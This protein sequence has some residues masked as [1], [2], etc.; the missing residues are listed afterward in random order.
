MTLFVMKHKSKRIICSI[1]LKVYHQM[2][3][4]LD[5]GGWLLIW[6]H[7]YMEDLPLSTNMTF[8]SNYYKPCTQYATSWCNIPNKARFN[9]TEQIIVAYPNKIVVYAYK[10]VFNRNIDYDWS[11]VIL[12]DHTK[13]I[14]KCRS[15]NYIHPYPMNTYIPGIVFNKYTAFS[16]Y[17]DYGTDMISGTLKQPNDN[18][19]YYC[20]LPYQISR[21]KNSV[22]M[23]L[24]IY[25][26]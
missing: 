4:S 15:K 25:V 8:F 1:L 24:A 21:T 19:W 5:G 10:G 7:S 11:G 23:T 16:Y 9:P 22:Q 13:I 14:D 26:H 2:D 6:Q 18:R 12:L 17:S 20:N 3:T